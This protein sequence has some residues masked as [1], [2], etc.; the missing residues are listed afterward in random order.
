MTV[1]DLLWWLGDEQIEVTA[2][3]V[4]RAIA[5]HMAEEEGPKPTTMHWCALCGAYTDEPLC[6]VC[7]RDVLLREG[8]NA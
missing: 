7:E 8:G 4:R 6:L 3:D 2:D 5:A 1:N